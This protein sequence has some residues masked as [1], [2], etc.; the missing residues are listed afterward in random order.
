LRAGNVN[1]HLAHGI[2]GQPALAAAA[3]FSG[4][5]GLASEGRRGDSAANNFRPKM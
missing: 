1:A 2:P 4:K 5:N 3:D